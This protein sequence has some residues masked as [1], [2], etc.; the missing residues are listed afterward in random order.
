[1]KAIVLKEFGGVDK[2]IL[3]EIPKPTIQPNEVLIEVKAISIN[4]VD[5]R[6][7]AGSAMAQHLKQY[8]P[9]I[10]G[11]DISGIVSE[12]GIE[13]IDF[14]IGDEAFGLVNFLGH[15]KAYAEYVAVPA[16]QLAVKPENINLTK[17]FNLVNL[18]SENY[19]QK[20]KNYMHN[21]TFQNNLSRLKKITKRKQISIYYKDYFRKI[22]PNQN[23]RSQV[24]N[25]L[26]SMEQ[27]MQLKYYFPTKDSVI[28]NS[29]NLLFFTKATF[30]LILQEQIKPS[31]NL[32]LQRPLLSNAFLTFENRFDITWQLYEL[33]HADAYFA[34]VPKRGAEQQRLNYLRGYDLCLQS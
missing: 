19:Y 20:M 30:P 32:L 34:P 9:L 18:H 33:G 24:K 8:L 14:K 29:T 21:F 16:N 26:S 6:T 5:V 15:G 11:W 28:A 7:R 2:L 13:V 1:M 31:L 4:P 25:V 12:V 23:V 22:R 27:L 17:K 10:L 3:S